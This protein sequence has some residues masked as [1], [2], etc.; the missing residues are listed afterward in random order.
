MTTKTN[1]LY[2]FEKRNS[3][4]LNTKVGYKSFTEAKKRAGKAP[5]I[6]T[7][8]FFSYDESYSES[9]ER[10]V[11]NNGAMPSGAPSIEREW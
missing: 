10:F 7:L 6:G 11:K 9:I 8:Y 2:G 3:G 1:R 5:V 4:S